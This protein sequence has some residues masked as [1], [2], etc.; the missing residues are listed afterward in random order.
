MRIRLV[1][2]LPTFLACLLMLLIFISVYV[3][4]QHPMKYA[5]DAKVISVREKFVAVE[6]NG[7]IHEYEGGTLVGNPAMK[8]GSVVYCE[9]WYS[10][11]VSCRVK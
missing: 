6:I 9:V 7:K 3:G 8:E 10:D 1:P 2:L 11:Y 5:G 4:R